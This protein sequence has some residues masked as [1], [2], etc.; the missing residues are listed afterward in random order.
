MRLPRVSSWF[1]AG[2]LL[3]TGVAAADESLKA[4]Y[5]EILRGDYEAGRASVGR[6]L[7]GGEA[8][9]QVEQVNRW[10]DSFQSV[11]SSREELR[12]KTFDWNVEHSKQQLDGGK[13][14]LALS[15]AAQAAAYA[16]DEQEYAASPWIQAL[17]A[18]ALAAAEEYGKSERWT[19]AH[20]FYLLL[21]RINEK[22]EEVKSLRERAARH[23]RL[24][25]IYEDAEDLR[26]R[27]KDV[28][29]DMLANSIRLVNEG[30]YE[31]P[32]FRKM[33]E[34][35][36]D[37]L[38]ALCTTTKLYKGTEAA[39]DF[40]GVA[41]PTM[42]EFFLGQLEQERRKVRD[43]SSSDYKDLIHLYNAIK[44]I[45]EKSVSLPE[46]LLIVEFM[47]GALG[48]LDDFTSIVWPV[49]A[50]EFDKM[51]VGNFV[52]VGIQLGLDDA[53]GRPGVLLQGRGDRHQRER[54][55]VDPRTLTGG[56]RRA[57]GRGQA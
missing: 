10:L 20:A 1:L 41:N 35:A 30:Y 56:C 6:L 45:N 4:A 7:V 12:Q 16:A 31:E 8:G 2:F 5:A 39:G 44:Q 23:A 22:D 38:E 17:R 11:V 27:I 29:E 18:K 25:L 50:P 42:R 37:N 33:A 24:E 34:G 55:S 52:G 43:R 3:V 21:H 48:E 32:D 15:F 54:P 14:Y 9:E 53:T 36:L 28:N 57:V 51:M 47:E 13:V 46:G 26:R 40:D 19:K 49:D